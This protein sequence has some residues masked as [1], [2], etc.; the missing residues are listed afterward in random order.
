MD[1]GHTD[2]TVALPPAVVIARNSS[3]TY[4]GRTVDARQIGQE[5]GMRPLAM[6][7]LGHRW[8]SGLLPIADVP[9]VAAN[10]REGPIPDMAHATCHRADILR[11]PLYTFETS[12]DIMR[13]YELIAGN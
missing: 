6:S 3:F 11:M 12:L 9:G 8:W 5:L 13:L 4:K 1:E 2:H 10:R 7:P